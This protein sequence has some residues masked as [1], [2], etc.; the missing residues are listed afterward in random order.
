MNERR[1]DMIAAVIREPGYAFA[2]DAEE[3]ELLDARLRIGAA[4]ILLDYD[5]AAGRN[6]SHLAAVTTDSA[7]DVGAQDGPSGPNVDRA[8]SALRAS[9]YPEHVDPELLAR[10]IREARMSVPTRTQQAMAVAVG[11]SLSAYASWEQG[12]HR[13]RLRD[14]QTVAEVT[15]YPLD[16]FL[17]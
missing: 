15:Q 12:S 8:M 10:R 16:F 4:E 7:T 9:E 17:A 13:P 2:L 11:V 3:R 6:S 5:R 1:R 14:L